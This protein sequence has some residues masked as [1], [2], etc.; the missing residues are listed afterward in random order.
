MALTESPLND[1][2]IDI[3]FSLIDK[4]KD[5]KIKKPE[6]EKFFK[7]LMDTQRVPK[8]RTAMTFMR[9]NEAKYQ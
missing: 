1:C 2:D 9:A 5:G 7:L 8:F 6:M 3:I 4:N